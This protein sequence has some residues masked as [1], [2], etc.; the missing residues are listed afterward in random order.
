[1][2]RGRDHLPS[3]DGAEVVGRRIDMTG[4][5]V[6]RLLVVE[7]HSIDGEQARW[8]CL[9]D[10]GRATDVLGGNLRSGHTVSCGCFA[11]A[12]ASIENRTH[13]MRGTPTYVSWL[14]MKARCLRPGDRSFAEYGGRGIT[15]CDRWRDSFANFLA[16]VGE[17]PPGTSIDRIDNS[18]SYEPGNVK[19]STAKEQ[20]NNRRRPRRT[21]SSGVEVQP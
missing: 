6:G 9:C 2:D 15:V 8:S 13:G 18:R 12:R 19:W 11:R 4:R 5:R 14:A 7:L 3:G 17:R 16:D 10:C 21:P 20:A 1:M